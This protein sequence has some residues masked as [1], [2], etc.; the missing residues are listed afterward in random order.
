[1]STSTG[2]I[3][4]ETAAEVLRRWVSSHFGVF[5]PRSV[6][7]PL[8]LDGSV[9]DFALGNW[10]MNRRS[11]QRA[12]SLA[13]E[14]LA[15]LSTIPGWDDAGQ[16]ANPFKG[17]SALGY[18]ALLRHVNLSYHAA[19]A[20]DLV[21]EG[22]PV[23]AWVVNRRRD[24]AQGKITAAQ[25]MVLERLP[26]WVWTDVDADAAVPSATMPWIH[27]RSIFELLAS[28]GRINRALAAAYLPGPTRAWLERLVREHHAGNAD[29]SLVMMFSAMPGWSWFD[30]PEPTAA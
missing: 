28:Q 13:P 12:G 16:S 26:G 30:P 27:L 8:A 11:E 21:I 6:V 3:P 17:R 18:I 24:F 1:M 22:Y 15:M 10:V 19:P 9:V 2:R 5:P 20:P 14:A 4:F 7:V 25:R 29:P 23:G